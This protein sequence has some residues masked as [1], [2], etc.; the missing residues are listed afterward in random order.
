MS[1]ALP[2]TIYTQR[3]T[4]RAHTRDDYA[5][6]AAMWAEPLV[7]RYIGGKPSPLR[8]SWMR[9]LS[10]R[11][12]WELLGYG[13]WA[14]ADRATDRYLGDVGFA[15]FK[16]EIEPSIAGVP[17]MGWALASYAHGQGYG[18]EAVRAALEWADAHIASPRIVCIIAPEN[19]ASLA[20]AGKADF[21]EIAQTAYLGNPTTMFERRVRG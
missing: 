19:T 8:E 13:Y 20:I 7:T 17:E 1:N 10:Y 9:M 3:L 6:C 4:L 21:V 14:V 11:G 12:L 15:D 2:P 16:R 18:T 5:A